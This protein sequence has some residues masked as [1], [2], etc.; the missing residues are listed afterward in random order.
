M[1]AVSNTS[2]LSSLAIIGRLVLLRER[3]GRVLIPPAVQ[4]ELAALSHATAK[5]REAALH[6]GWLKVER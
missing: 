1:P 6:G 3:C 2:P 4:R 5:A